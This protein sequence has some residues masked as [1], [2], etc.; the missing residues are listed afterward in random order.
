MK[1]LCFILLLMCNKISFA[2]N[3]VFKMQNY[4][5][6]TP[7]AF[8]FLK[9]DELPISEYTGVPNI[10]IPIYNIETD[11]VTVPINLTYHAAGNRVSDEA[12]W[13]GLG[14]DL[15]FGSITQ[16][17]NDLDD[18]GIG[19]TRLKPDYN[20]SP[21]P[22]F[23]SRPY[24]YGCGGAVL[25]YPTPIPVVAPQSQYAYTIYTAYYMP[26]NGDRFN[27]NLG[28]DIVTNFLYDS[29]PDIFVANLSGHSIKFIRD[30]NGSIKLLNSEGYKVSRSGDIYTI[31]TPEGD[32]YIFE[33]NTTVNSY[34]GSTVPV[35]SVFVG[36][37][38]KPSSRI[39][40]LQKLLRKIKKI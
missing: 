1:K 13:V 5:P 40:M 11:G 15:N 29:E 30:D 21:I 35:S 16:E 37:E 39:W 27:Q 36:G 12:S 20:G 10:S 7:S 9:Y 23:Y 33:K 26:I 24:R 4:H 17:I 19:V 18:Y 22:S 34:S 6:V 3:D 38:T 28:Q 25:P 14:W 31:M 8:Q 2:Q 32:S